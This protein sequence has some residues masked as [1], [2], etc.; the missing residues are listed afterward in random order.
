MFII[1][2]HLQNVAC[3]PPEIAKSGPKKAQGGNKIPTAALNRMSFGRKEDA[4]AVTLSLPLGFM[5]NFEVRVLIV[6]EQQG[7]LGKSLLSSGP[8][9][10]HR[11]RRGA[12]SGWEPSCPSTDMRSS[13]ADT[14][15]WSV[16]ATHPPTEPRLHLCIL[17]SCQR[18]STRGRSH[19]AAQTLETR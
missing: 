18:P 12:N 14:I 13:P 8:R 15:E 11:H 2:T 17:P 1:C 10:S 19:L 3:F 16:V 6:T 5:P 4:A 9:S 7:D